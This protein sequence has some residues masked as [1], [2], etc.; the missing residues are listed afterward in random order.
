MNDSNRSY[1]ES[2]LQQL[3]AAGTYRIYGHELEFE[4]DAGAVAG[5]ARRGRWMPLRPCLCVQDSPENPC[6]CNTGTLWW[7][8]E[9]AIVAQ[10]KSERKDHHGKELQFFDVAVESKIMVESLQPVSAGVLKSLGNGVTPERLLDLAADRDT[11][12]SAVPGTMQ[13]V[14][15]DILIGI[16]GGLLYDL[17]KDASI[18]DLLE[19]LAEEKRGQKPS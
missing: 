10:G 6:P 19:K 3:D 9:D 16:L 7:L 15:K 17:L 14:V 13:S 8:R 12:G 11:D 18:L 5:V 4:Q 1:K 2:K